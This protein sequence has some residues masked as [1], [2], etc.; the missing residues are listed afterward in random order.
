L[1][2]IKCY[3]TK[4]GVNQT[5][6]KIHQLLSSKGAKKILNEYDDDGKIKSVSFQLIIN[7]EPIFYKL[8]ARVNGVYKVMYGKYTEENVNQRRAQAE[9]VAWR[10]T[11]N[12][13]DSQIAFIEAG[14]AEVAEVF[15]PYMLCTADE[16]IYDRFKEKGLTMIDY[17]GEA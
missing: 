9:R 6:A 4:I 3:T 10:I 8:P 7:S 15:L 12:W 17:K 5:V 11:L 14:C 1:S 16:T 13:I 2:K